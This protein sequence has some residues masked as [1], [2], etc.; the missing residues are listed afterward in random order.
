[1]AEQYMP[2]EFVPMNQFVDKTP[3]RLPTVI[4]REGPSNRYH[5]GTIFND[6]VTCII[7]IE[8]QVSMGYRVTIMLKTCFKEW[9]K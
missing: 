9:L 7:L 5:G 2:G 6:V 1:M 3:G 8:K 4:G